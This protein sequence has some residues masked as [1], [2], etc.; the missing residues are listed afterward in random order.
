MKRK[1]LPAAGYRPNLRRRIINDWQ[2]Y[3]LLLPAVIYFF[4]YT[5]LPMYGLQIVFKDYKFVKGILGSEWVG[6]KHFEDFFNAYYFW[7][8]IKNTF[9]LNFLNL[10][11]AFPIPIVMAILLNQ[12]EHKGYKKFTQTA[13]YIP[14]FIST[15]VM[16]G[17]LYLFLSPENGI[18]NYFIEK[19]GGKAVHFM[20]LSQWFRPLYIATEIWQHAGWNTIL[21]IAALAGVSPEIYEAATIDGATKRQ[22]IWHIDIAH[23]MPIA[24][25][26]LIL[27][28]G[29]L[30][31]SNVDKTLLM[32]TSGNIS[33]SDILGL[34]VYKVG[35]AGS[36]PQP[37]YAAAIGLFTNVINFVMI[38]SV[39]FVSKKLS[40]TSLF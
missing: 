37:S 5:Y 18:I 26:L 34:Y 3:V 32:Q 8:L 33:T 31:F 30:M 2:I 36:P 13:I 11:I 38:L 15:T 7:R 25:M 35:L 39:N 21:F 23:I 1:S 10:I 27:N 24:I 12:F 6:F 40:D 19:L 20:I 22:K 29:R 17:I 28:S 9:L 14:H 4:V 16:V